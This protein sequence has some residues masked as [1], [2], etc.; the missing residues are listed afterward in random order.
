MKISIIIIGIKISENL[1]LS[2]IVHIYFAKQTD[3]VLDKCYKEAIPYNNN[4]EQIKVSRLW[5]A[6]T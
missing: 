3:G 1:E 6:K 5:L 2:R 4:R